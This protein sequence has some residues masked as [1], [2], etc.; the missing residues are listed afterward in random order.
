MFSIVPIKNSFTTNCHVR[1][2]QFKEIIIYL[3]YMFHSIYK[4]WTNCLY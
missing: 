4:W 3:I 1:I 2:I